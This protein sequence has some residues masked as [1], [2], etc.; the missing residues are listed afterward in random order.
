MRAGMLVI[1]VLVTAMFALPAL[2]QDHMHE[3][4]MDDKAA[5]GEVSVI[6]HHKV[7][8]FDKWLP[9]F[10]ADA[11]RREA[12]GCTGISVYQDADDPTMVTIIVTVESLEK[13]QAF[14]GSEEMATK[15]QEAGVMGPPEVH[16]TK[17]YKDY[18]H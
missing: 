6:I 5:S 1:A 12:G 10:E 17:L 18:A 3:T 13:A 7:A 8:D 16:I 9:A 11:A 2:A 4:M 15:M 14:L